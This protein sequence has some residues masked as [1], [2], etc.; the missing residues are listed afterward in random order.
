MDSERKLML[1]NVLEQ[2]ERNKYFADK[3]EALLLDQY[4]LEGGDAIEHPSH[5]YGWNL[6]LTIE[7][8]LN[9]YREKVRKTPTKSGT[10]Y[11]DL[12][13]AFKLDVS[14][15]LQRMEMRSF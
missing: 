10:A 2:I 14:E 8:K 11:N 15:E 1:E 3:V 4:K 9:P 13:E 5:S 12:I 6:N 7:R